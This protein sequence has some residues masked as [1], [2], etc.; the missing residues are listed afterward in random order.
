M[1]SE[2]TKILFYTSEH[3]GQKSE[4]SIVLHI[5]KYSDLH[6]AG[7][8]SSW[9]WNSKDAINKQSIFPSYVN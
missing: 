5:Y 3:M 6:R 4:Y 1:G 9:T 8:T 7:E 2:G